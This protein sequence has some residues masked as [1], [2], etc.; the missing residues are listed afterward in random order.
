[1]FLIFIFIDR[2]VFIYRYDPNVAGIGT[3]Y[4]SAPECFITGARIT[5]KADIW[6]AG[7]ILYNMTYGDLPREDS[8]RPPYGSR[9]TRSTNVEDILYNCLQVDEYRRGSHSW[10]ARHPYTINPTAF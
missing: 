1:V 3:P 6:S 4:F 9:P 5:S 2:Y 10:L 8:S 7:A